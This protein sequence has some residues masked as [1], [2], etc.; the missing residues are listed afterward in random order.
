MKMINKCSTLVK[1]VVKK[2][3]DLIG[4]TLVKKYP[5]NP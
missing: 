5:F 1:R 3:V 2:A 4:Y